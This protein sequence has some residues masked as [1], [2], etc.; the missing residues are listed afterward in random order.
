MNLEV[1]IVCPLGAKC[2][3]ARD[4]AIYRCGWY[5]YVR[6]YDMNIGQEVDEWACG[7]KH[8]PR[9]LVENSGMQRQT[10]ANVADFKNEMVKANQVSQ[11]VLLA[12]V[13]Q[14]QMKTLEVQK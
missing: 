1:K 13:Q 8:M 9:L 6:G 4:G 11:Q 7:I 2:E 3:E 14:A 12:S 5:T 10:A